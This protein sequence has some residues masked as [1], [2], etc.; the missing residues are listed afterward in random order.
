MTSRTNPK[1]EPTSLFKEQHFR[2]TADESSILLWI[3]DH[4]GS[5]TYFNPAWAK[6]TGRAETDELGTG[7]MQH[8]HSGDLERFQK[9]LQRCV[10]LKQSLQVEFRL[11]RH[12]GEYRWLLSQGIPRYS[13]GNDFAGYVGS[14]TDISAAKSAEHVSRGYAAAVLNTLRRL[15]TEPVID[16]FLENTLASMAQQLEVRSASLWLLDQER[17]S[18]LLALEYRDGEVTRASDD[19][20][21]LRWELARLQEVQAQR[22]L[23]FPDVAE[24]PELG[25]IRDSLVAKGMKSLLIVPLQVGAHA[26]G[27]FVA[28]EPDPRRYETHEL[29]LAKTLAYQASMAVLVTR[30]ATQARTAAVQQERSRMAGEIHDSLAQ[31]FTGIVVQLEAAEDVLTSA[32]EQALGHLLR[33]KALARQSLAEARRSVFALRLQALE[34]GDL[35]TALSTLCAQYEVDTGTRTRFTMWG[36]PVALEAQ[37]ESHFLRICQEALTNISRHARAQL[38]S[39]ELKFEAARITVKVSDDGCGFDT[40]AERQAGFGLPGMRW[41]VKQMGGRLSVR[42]RPDAGTTIVASVPILPIDD[43]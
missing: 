20:A 21:A 7:W 31:G 13:I 9:E 38:V 5:M 32:P 11:R 40:K 4:A 2:A 37:T 16:S 3:T 12:D 39:V 36:Q 18:T 19:D 35:A 15:T 29:E 23:V 27:A 17:R 10:Q 41:R 33:A 30:L 6:F 14:S 34:H 24:H 22:P 43:R 1:G 28:H 8:I 26:I 42:S 25:D